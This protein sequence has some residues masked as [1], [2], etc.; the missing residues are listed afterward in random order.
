MVCVF[1]APFPTAISF[2]DFESNSTIKISLTFSLD[3]ATSACARFPNDTHQ[4]CD[5]LAQLYGKE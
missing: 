4:D 5:P 2:V 1:L 3:P